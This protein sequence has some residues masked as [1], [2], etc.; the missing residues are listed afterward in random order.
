MNS[1]TLIYYAYSLKAFIET[2][3]YPVQLSVQDGEM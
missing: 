3:K 1:T 2:G